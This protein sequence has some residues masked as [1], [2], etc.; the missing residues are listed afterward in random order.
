M[1]EDIQKKK[2]LRNLICVQYCVLKLLLVLLAFE[3]MGI[4]LKYMLKDEVKEVTGN[5]VVNNTKETT[6][7]VL[8]ICIDA[9]HGGKDNGSDYNNRYE[10][11]D[12][13]KIA[14]AVVAY[15]EEREVKVVM[16]REEDVFLSLEERC[17][18]ANDANADYFI[19]LHRN[20]GDGYG[21]ETWIYSGASEETVELAEN[22]MDGLDKAGI[23]KNRGVRKGT[24]TSESGNYYVNIHSDM[25]ACIVELGFINDGYDNN[26]FDEKLSDYGMAIGEAVLKAA[27]YTK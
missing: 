26:L 19:S 5:V 18:I 22:L 17:Q 21:V 1:K 8:T 24:Q 7:E 3:A 13:L 11:N 12:N 10:K 9:G 4:G 2:R 27:G 23:Q 20:T 25:P 16:T 6:E 15:L 14:K